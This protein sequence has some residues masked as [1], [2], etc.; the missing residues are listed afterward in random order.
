MT[1]F[2]YGVLPVSIIVYLAGT[3][4]RKRRRQQEQLQAMQERQQAEQND[5]P[6][7]H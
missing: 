6:Q 2:F 7:A 3:G 5:T 1:F 4:T